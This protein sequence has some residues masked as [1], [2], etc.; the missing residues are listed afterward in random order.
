MT[1]ELIL[2]YVKRQQRRNTVFALPA[3][4]IR[5]QPPESVEFVWALFGHW[6]HLQIVQRTVV[7]DTA[8][9]G[10]DIGYDVKFYT[11]T[12]IDLMQRDHAKRE[13]VAA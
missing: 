4:A 1:G 13:A 9:V 2:R 10:L 12:A 3:G 6:R 5:Q 8:Y 7:D 11:Q